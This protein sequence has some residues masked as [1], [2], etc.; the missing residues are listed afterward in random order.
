MKGINNEVLAKIEGDLLNKKYLLII[1]IIAALFVFIGTRK[2]HYYPFTNS[3]ELN[4]GNVLDVVD[5]DNGLVAIW[6]KKLLFANH[7]R[8]LIKVLSTDINGVQSEPRVVATDGEYVYAI[9]G[10]IYN[11]YNFYINEKF[12]KYS[13]SGDYLGE[14]YR[15]NYDEDYYVNSNQLR[16][17]IIRDGF[18][19]ITKIQDHNVQLIKVSTTPAIEGAAAESTVV[20]SFEIPEMAQTGKYNID[21]NRIEINNRFDEVYFYDMTENKLTFHPEI[22]QK[23]FRHQPWNASIIFSTFTKITDVLYHLG[24][25]ILIIT[26][27]YA[28]FKIG[29]GGYITPYRT[30]IVFILLFL[31]AIVYYA[32]IELNEFDEE[33]RQRT[34]SA[35]ESAM[36][37]VRYFAKNEMDII[38]GKEPEDFKAKELREWTEWIAPYL[39]EACRANGKEMGMYAQI[40]AFNKDGGA[41]LLID[42]YN[43]YPLGTLYSDVSISSDERV[44]SSDMMVYT[45]EKEVDGTYGFIHAPIYDAQNNIVGFLEMGSEYG[46]LRYDKIRKVI[47]SAMQLVALVVF[48]VMLIDV[49]IKYSKELIEYSA[50]RRSQPTEAKYCLSNTYDFLVTGLVYMDGMIMVMAIASISTDSTMD[51][52]LLFAIPFTAYRVGSWLGSVMTSPL[53]GRFG[54]KRMGIVASIISGATFFGMSFA[55]QQKNVYIFA[56][57]KFL[58]GI[59]LESVLYSLAEGIPY[60][61]EDMDYRNRKIAESQSATAAATL[62]FMMVAGLVAS[63]LGFSAMYLIG[64]VVCVILIPFSFIIFGNEE[65]DEEIKTLQVWKAFAKPRALVYIV[66]M[67]L[68]ISLATSYDEYL[69]PLISESAGLTEIEMTSIAV[70]SI[71]ISYFGESIVSIFNSWDPLKAMITAL[72][73]CGVSMMILLL[74]MSIL[75]A[76]IVLFIYSIMIRITEVHRINWLIKLTASDDV[77]G[78]DVLE[79]YFALEDGFKVLHGPVLGPLCAISSSVAVGCLGL[80]CL[81]SPRLYGIIVSK[82]KINNSHEED[83]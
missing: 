83:K 41:Y 12:L 17:V 24:A 31:S 30:A 21:E 49:I 37:G 20:A 69:F 47:G 70:F 3:I 80:L 39:K 35:V 50:I 77:E 1:P 22:T 11:D 73:V 76:T 26:V 4:Q 51:M 56:A 44:N 67:V 33:Q 53:L 62:I 45:V 63:T 65:N 58:E 14:L 61:I 15:Q 36:L 82:Q 57:C 13:F 38:G 48:T 75:F 54:E 79:N 10:E 59:F 52:A 27:I 66:L 34:V 64:L 42:T 8:E 78:K 18:A 46:K 74:N 23:R 43:E 28:V 25:V 72:S 68:T 29:S 19:Y 81:I 16:D 6:A 5:D 9:I 2:I 7:N 71:T 55:I 60:E 32:N 40:Y